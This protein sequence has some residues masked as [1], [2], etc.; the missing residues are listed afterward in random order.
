MLF[1]QTQV[2]DKHG[3]TPLLAAIWEGHTNCVAILL[4]GGADKTGTTPDGTS[5]VNAAEK[6][7]IKALIA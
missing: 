5:Y 1:Q 7:D 3:I 6:D 2:K 4:K